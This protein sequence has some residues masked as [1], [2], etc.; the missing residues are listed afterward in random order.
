MTW[1]LSKALFHASFQALGFWPYEFWRDTN[2]QT[3][4][5]VLPRIIQLLISSTQVFILFNFQLRLK[6]K[7]NAQCYVRWHKGYSLSVTYLPRISRNTDLPTSF[8]LWTAELQ[9]YKFV[10]F[11]VTKFVVICYSENRKLIQRLYFSYKNIKIQIL[12]YWVE[13]EESPLHKFLETKF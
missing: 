5:Y 4:A 6:R 8:R 9:H 12:K 10:L 1:S 3:L 13:M 7:R 2:I 11:E